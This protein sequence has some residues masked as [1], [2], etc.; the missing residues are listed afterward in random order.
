M[1][2]LR[3][4]SDKAENEDLICSM[5]DEL[6]PD[7]RSDIINTPKTY[8]TGRESMLMWAVWRLKTKVVQKLLDYGANPKYMNETG[9]GVSTYWDQDAIRHNEDA[10]CEI[11]K[12]LHTAGADLSQSFS[13]SWSIVRRARE[14]G[15]EKLRL[16]LE[17]LDQH[18]ASCEF[19]DF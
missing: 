7:A 15:F 16:T 3:L 4:I 18:Y 19:Y 6:D 12:M 1:S 17:Q 13:Q 5:L 2:L 9:N 14:C 8:Y 10:A 11:A